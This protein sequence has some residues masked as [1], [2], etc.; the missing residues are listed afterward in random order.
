A[1]SAWHFAGCMEPP[2]GSGYG[3]E[4]AVVCVAGNPPSVAV[5]AGCRCGG[6][7]AVPG[8]VRRRTLHLLGRVAG[9][10]RNGTDVGQLARQPQPVP[11]RHG[12]VAGGGGET[13]PDR[14]GR[15]Y[16]LMAC[17]IVHGAGS[18]AA[19]TGLAASAVWWAAGS[20]Q[21]PCTS[22]TLSSGSSGSNA[23]KAGRLTEV[24]SRVSSSPFS[25]IMRDILA[26]V[27]AGIPAFEVN[28]LFRNTGVV[29]MKSSAAIFQREGIS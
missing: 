29:N 12:A 20:E 6:P 23:Y 8:Y 15:P 2:D 10:C 11:R 27:G 3:A 4:P 17:G 18:G 1:D 7:A 22:Y 13:V 5:R 16:R 28:L 26:A 19:G 14:H 25:T 24:S 9:A 21:R